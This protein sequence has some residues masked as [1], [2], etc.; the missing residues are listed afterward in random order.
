MDDSLTLAVQRMLL[1]V[2]SCVSLGNTHKKNV[3]HN[4]RIPDLNLR[5]SSDPYSTSQWLESQVLEYNIRSMQPR[6]HYVQLPFLKS[7]GLWP[8]QFASN[9]IIEFSCDVADNAQSFQIQRDM[10]HQA[11]RL[12]GRRG[13]SGKQ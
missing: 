3:C 6:S 12:V 10:P 2:R 5:P 8:M 11:R 9:R 4:L 1:I 13:G 7:F